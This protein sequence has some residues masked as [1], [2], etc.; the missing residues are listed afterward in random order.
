[1][2]VCCHYGEEIGL[3]DDLTLL[4]GPPLHSRCGLR[5]IVGGLKNETGSCL[6]C[7]SRDVLTCSACPNARR[8]SH[9]NWTLHPV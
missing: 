5:L 2:T 9:R 7:G 1:V 3:D 8:S 6:C 4:Q